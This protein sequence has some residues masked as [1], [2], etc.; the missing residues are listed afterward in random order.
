MNFLPIRLKKEPLIEVI[1]QVQFEGNQGIGDILPGVIFTELKKTYSD[2]NY[3]VSPRPTFRR[4][5]HKLIPT[6]DSLRRC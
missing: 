4:R 2:S 3:A 1:W 5:S 6:Y